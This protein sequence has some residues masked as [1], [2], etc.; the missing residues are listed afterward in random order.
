MKYFRM[1]YGEVVMGRSYI[2]IILLN[3]SIPS[4]SH[5]KDDGNKEKK[6]RIDMKKVR[7]A[8]EVLDLLK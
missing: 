2:N 4:F 1:S 5:N 7:H 3:A 8:N 6:N